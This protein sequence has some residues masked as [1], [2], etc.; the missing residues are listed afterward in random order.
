MRKKWML[1]LGSVTFTTLLLLSILG[2]AYGT[3]VTSGDYTKVGIVRLHVLA[4]SDTDEDQALKRKVRDAVIDYMRPY[5][6]NSINKDQAENILAEQI[7]IVQEIARQVVQNQGFAYP[8]RV[9]LGQHLFPTKTYGELALPAGNYQALRV[10]IGKAEGQNWWC[11]L[12]P[13]LC[14]VDVTNSL[15]VSEQTKQ[16]NYEISKQQA[17]EIRFKMLDWWHE[18]KSGL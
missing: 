12:F 1:I 11:V 10:L 15:A 5:M 17:P 3:A 2:W 4:N 7:P 8:V 13:P 18:Q 6:L 9:E 16:I 14:F